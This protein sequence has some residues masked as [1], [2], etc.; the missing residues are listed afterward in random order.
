MKSFQTYDC[1][2]KR[3][4]RNLCTSITTK[5][6]SPILSAL[7]SSSQKIQNSNPLSRLRNQPQKPLIIDT[8]GQHTSTQLLLR[9]LT[10]CKHLPKKQ[11]TNQPIAVF[12]PADNT[13]VTAILSSWQNSLPAV[14]LSP[15]YPAAALT[16]LLQTVTPSIILTSHSLRHALPPTS[17]PI[18]PIDDIL[19]EEKQK[20]EI[21]FEEIESLQIPIVNSDDTVLIFFTSGTTGAPKG[22]VWTNDMLTYQLETLSDIW[23]WNSNDRILNTLPLHHIHGLINV[24]KCSLYNN[25]QLEMHSAFDAHSVWST[26]MND[27]NRPSIFMGV[28]SIYQKLITYFKKAP[29]KEQEKMTNSAKQMRLFVSGSASLSSNDYDEWFKITGHNILERYG[30]TETGITLSHDYND[31]RKG[32]LGKPL[33]GVSIKLNEN[34]FKSDNNDN[35][36]VGE[37]LVKGKGIFP[38][39]WNNKDKSSQV[40]TEDGYFKTGDVVQDLNN[41]GYLKLLGRLNGDI[42]KS[43]GYKIS[44]LEIED[45]IKDVKGVKDCCVI[46]I[47]DNT[48]GERIIATIIVN[49]DFIT[50]AE[51]LINDIKHLVDEKL[52]KYKVPR[53]FV[54]VDDLPRNVMGKVQKLMLKTRL[55]T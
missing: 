35:S 46:G 45:I 13:F 54:I 42:I 2:M 26:F 39:Y 7:Q 10:L 22:V 37:L 30:M 19:L 5:Q 18:L 38:G 6:Y 55:L 3:L 40:F 52:P 27:K 25:A 21:E 20:Q 53:Q 44:T 8:H 29:L 1:I 28:P 24:V 41:D 12:L 34:E 11:E 14:P 17:I 33:P 48:L 51:D 16:P 43:S 49:D 32:L 9:S 4:Q 50:S 31:R 23:K 47:P 15:L 36:N